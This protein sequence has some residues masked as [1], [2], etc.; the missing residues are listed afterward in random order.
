MREVQQPDASGKVE[1]SSVRAPAIGCMRR[2]GETWRACAERY[3]AE[4]GLQ[5]EVL[6]VFDLEVMAGADDDQA[7]L[8]ALSSWDCLELFEVEADGS[9][10]P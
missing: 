2:E 4:F 10:K 9:V 5:T 7:C 6:E 1:S 3:A 8:A